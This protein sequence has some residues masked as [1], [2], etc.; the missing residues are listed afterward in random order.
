M[1]TKGAPCCDYA[2]KLLYG[3]T[4]NA[5]F[6][7]FYAESRHVC[8]PVYGTGRANVFCMLRKEG[9]NNGK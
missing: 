9:Q 2:D 4:L 7:R 8:S 1:S 3:E 5:R 6:W